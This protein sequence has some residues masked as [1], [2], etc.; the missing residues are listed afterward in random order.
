MRAAGLA[1]VTLAVLLAQNEGSQKAPPRNAVEA[2]QA[3]L[4]AAQLGKSDDARRDYEKA[5]RLD[6]DYGEAWQALAKLQVEQ[7]DLGVCRR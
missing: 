3:G 2:F 4:K 1:W 7:R 5:A 6:P